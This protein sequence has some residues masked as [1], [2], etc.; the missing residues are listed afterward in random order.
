MLQHFLQNHT[1]WRD[2]FEIMVAILKDKQI[3]LLF[4]LS[5][6]PENKATLIKSSKKSKI[7]KVL[8]A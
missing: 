2:C 4:L 3:S 8:E 7:L 6:L 1:E 5:P